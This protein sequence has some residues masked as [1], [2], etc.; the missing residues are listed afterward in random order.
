M[1]KVKSNAEKR[2]S[3]CKLSTQPEFVYRRVR[4]MIE[5]ERFEP[6]AQL[7]FGQKIYSILAQN[8]N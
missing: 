1:S 3:V 2:E 5:L 6:G 7:V 4:S 8:V